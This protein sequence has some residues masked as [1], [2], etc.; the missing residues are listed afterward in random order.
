[1]RSVIINADDFGI[2]ECVN[3]GIAIAIEQNAIS[4][5]SLMAGGKAFL[6]AIE[7]VKEKK[8]PTG[9]HL[10][11]DEEFPVLPIEEV[12]SLITKEGNFKHRHQLL[13][14]LL[15]TSKI[16]A[17][18]VE[19]CFSAQI[20]KCLAHKIFI[21]HIDG[22][23]HVHVFPQIAP[24]VAKLC[25]KYGLK[26]IRLPE[27]PIGLIPPIWSN[28]KQVNRWVVWT[29]CQAAKRSFRRA[30]LL[31]PERFFGISCGGQ[32]QSQHINSFL[33]QTGENTSIELMCHPG[34][35]DSELLSRYKDWGYNWAN[36]LNQLCSVDTK[37]ILEKNGAR[38]INFGELRNEK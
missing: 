29:F 32:I 5:T 26:K 3:Q 21:D 22:H 16:S 15:F 31:W 28:Q 9:I 13:K 17:R 1:M 37:K 8:I 18:E 14:E 19:N 38:L 35:E 12:S 23:G 34:L 27:E 7:L 33:R 24:I 30:D 10:T 20:E 6:H 36:E 2:S 25:K 11:L 4:S